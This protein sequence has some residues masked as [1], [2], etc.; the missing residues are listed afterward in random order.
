MPGSDV[1]KPGD[2]EG[3]RVC[4][5]DR[6]VLLGEG[7]VVIGRSSYCSLVLDQETLSRVHASLRVID[8]G[9]ELTD[10]GSS[11]GTFVNGVAISAPTR[12]RP[13]DD[14]RLGTVK[15]WVEV[16]SARISVQTS[17]FAPVRLDPENELTRE[18]TTTINRQEPMGEPPKP[19]AQPDKPS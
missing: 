2:G 13:G 10:L 17:R 8:D 18:D 7:E 9:I 15:I 19:P 5:Q 12:V 1:P 6:H 16:A 11:N 3:Y 14:L 4:A